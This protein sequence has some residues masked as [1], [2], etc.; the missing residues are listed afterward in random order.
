MYLQIGSI[1]QVTVLRDTEIGYMVGNEDEVIF[2]LNNDVAG[3]IEDGDT[4]DVFLYLDLQN[5]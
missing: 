5:R 2:L 4:I 3:E 1:E